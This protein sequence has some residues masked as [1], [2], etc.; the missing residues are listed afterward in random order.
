MIQELYYCKW[1]SS[2]TY[3]TPNHFTICWQRQGLTWPF[4][5]FSSKEYIVDGDSILIGFG[6]TLE[7]MLSSQF[8]WG[9]PLKY[10]LGSLLET[11][12]CRLVSSHL[13]SYIDLTPW[14]SG[15]TDLN[16]F[17]TQQWANVMRQTGLDFRLSRG[18][19]SLYNMLLSYNY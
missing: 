13:W 16:C 3:A 15:G 17:P 1:H 12:C 8:C 2:S 7:F 4:F 9:V 14:N 18:A 11:A 10:I 19:L 6:Y 5:V